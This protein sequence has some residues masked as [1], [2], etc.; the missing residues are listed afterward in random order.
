MTQERYTYSGTDLSSFVV[1]ERT[2]GL[3]F[4]CQTVLIPKLKI[5]KPEDEEEKFLNFLFGPTDDLVFSTNGSFR[6]K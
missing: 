4:L 5:N 3:F 2:E 6:N 1:G